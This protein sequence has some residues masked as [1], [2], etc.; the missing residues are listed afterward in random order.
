MDRAQALAKNIWGATSWLLGLLGAG[1]FFT[2]GLRVQSSGRVGFVWP[3]AIAL[4]AVATGAVAYALISGITTSRHRKAAEVAASR[5]GAY[6]ILAVAFIL[7]LA[8]VAV[9]PVFEG[10]AVVET[11]QAN[12]PRGQADEALAQ[13]LD[14][15]A[16][17]ASNLDLV[18]D[19]C[20]SHLT[21]AQVS[22]DWLKDCL[23][24]LQPPPPSQAQAT[25][26][27]DALRKNQSG[28]AG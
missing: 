21:D 4:I 22:D 1:A 10:I 9:A 17:N 26:L 3:A 20:K 11:L 25:N 15:Y 8:A 7:Q 13:R 14:D 18:T 12:D 27:A 2:I 5:G 19:Y 6:A 24:F 23:L 16:S 28:G